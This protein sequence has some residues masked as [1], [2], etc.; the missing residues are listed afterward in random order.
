MADPK[1]RLL[2]VEDDAPLRLMYRKAF[3]KKGFEVVGEGENG[4][5]GIALF[6]TLKP[7]ITLMDINM[8]VMN[9]IH[10][11]KGIL[12]ADPKAFVIM[13]TSEFQAELWDE[14]LLAGAE[15]Y[16]RKETPLTE[17]HRIILEN[18]E[19]HLRTNGR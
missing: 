6:K 1:I 5:E 10:G 19:E 18:W 8:P 15:Y 16:I 12:K 3:E 7:D 14:C 2:L 11:L 17:T 9:G 13:L 4:Q